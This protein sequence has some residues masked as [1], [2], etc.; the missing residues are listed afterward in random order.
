MSVKQILKAREIICIVPDARKAEAVRN[1]FE[2]EISPDYPASIL[3]TH[4][5]T[6][7]YLDQESASLLK[8]ETITN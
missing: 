6:T 2:L 3:R 7:I 5:N 1:C 8:A 4:L